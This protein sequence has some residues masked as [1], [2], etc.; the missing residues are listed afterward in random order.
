MADTRKEDLKRGIE[1]FL[2]VIQAAKEASKEL[3]KEKE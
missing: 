2:A 3:K 1:K